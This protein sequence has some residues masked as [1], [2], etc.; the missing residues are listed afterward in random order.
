MGREAR[1]VRIQRKRADGRAIEGY[2]QLAAR[3]RGMR[4]FGAG[5]WST[6]TECTPDGEHAADGR[7]G[8]AN[9]Q[10]AAGGRVGRGFN[11]SACRH[12]GGLWTRYQLALC[13][14]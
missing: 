11:F 1:V 13:V 14:L 9:Q 2:D 8:S 4:D 3:A 10:A 7:R 5:S 6:T 12:L